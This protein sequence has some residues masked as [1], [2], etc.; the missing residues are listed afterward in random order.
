MAS[1]IGNGNG[2]RRATL[3]RAVN[4]RIREIS[5]NVD[6]F[7]VLCE[8]GRHDCDRTVELNAP[9]WEEIERA[10]HAFVV[11]PGHEPR[12]CGPVE[13]EAGAYRVVALSR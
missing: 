11:A 1:D 6:A 4:E 7:E 5:G 10:E 12:G 3:I 13:S 8:C 2:F 9:R